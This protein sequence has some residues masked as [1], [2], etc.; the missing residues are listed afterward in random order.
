MTLKELF[1]KSRVSK[2]AYYS[3]IRKERLLPQSV[4]LLARILKVRASTLLEEEN[5]EVKKIQELRKKLGKI[6]EIY[7]EANPENIWHTLILL[8]E[9]PLERLKRGLLRGKKFNFHR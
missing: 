9:K 8:E 3:L 2:T 6:I 5:P 7:P 4:Y 1:E